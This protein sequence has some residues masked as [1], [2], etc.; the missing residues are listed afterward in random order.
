[1]KTPVFTGSGTAIVT[2][3]SEG[4]IDFAAFARLIEAQ[5]AGGTAALVVCGTT[6]EGATLTPEE[7]EAMFRFAA[8][9]SA[10]RMKIVAGIGSND[11]AAALD[12]AKRAEQAGADG[13]LMVTPYYNK[14]TQAGLVKHFT[15]VAD[16]TALPIIL[17]NVPSRTGVGIA[18]ETYAILAGHPNINAV[19]E[20][21]GNIGE[22]AKTVALCDGGLNFYSGNDSDTVAMMALGAKGV[23]SVASNIVPGVVSKL[24]ALCLAGDYAAAASLNRAYMDLFSVLFR[25]VNPIPVKTAMA[26][27]GLCG[28]GMRLPLVPM[29]EANRAA[30]AQVLVRHGLLPKETM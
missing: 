22:F 25:E 19:K 26:M 7:H 6:G 23:V 5:A 1:M 16:R 18:P 20:A 9:K 29:G 11:T 2:P 28:D 14:T 4:T 10:G 17:Y 27:M 8:E 30:L 24:C 15:Y 3:L 12:M 21:S 13:L